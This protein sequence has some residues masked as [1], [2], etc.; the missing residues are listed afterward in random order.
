MRTDQ[1]QPL[2]NMVMKLGFRE[3]RE[4]SWLAER[5]L[6]YQVDPIPYS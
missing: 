3:N 2:V 1:W 6:A 4:I 5:L